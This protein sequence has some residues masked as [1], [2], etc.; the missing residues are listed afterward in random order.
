MDAVLQL[1]VLV[2]A[3]FAAGAVNALAG[4]GTLLVYP[5]LLAGGLPPVAANV[6]SILGLIPEY[7]GA[8]Y[9]YRGEITRVK[10]RLPALGIAS[11][12]GAIAGASVLLTTPSKLFQNVV[13]FLVLMS[14]NLLLTRLPLAKSLRALVASASHSTVILSH[15]QIG[16]GRITGHRTRLAR[17]G[18]T[19]S[20]PVQCP[21][22]AA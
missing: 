10:R 8:A 15:G 2:V 17:P 22:V 16:C 3:G 11:V 5:A 6:T 7:V 18:L 20:E 12:A 9:A 19:Y 4:G 14:S 1:G 21:K 13:P